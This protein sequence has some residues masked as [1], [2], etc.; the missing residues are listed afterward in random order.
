MLSIFSLCA[1]FSRDVSSIMTILRGFRLLFD[2]LLL[3]IS[4]AI[5]HPFPITSPSAYTTTTNRILIL[6]LPVHFPT[7]KWVQ[8]VKF[9]HNLAR[10]H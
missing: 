9:N 4:I 3:L 7:V 2:V 1:R 5:F 8:D 10:S 6:G